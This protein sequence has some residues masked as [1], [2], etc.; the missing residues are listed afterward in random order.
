[1]TRVEKYALCNF[2]VFSIC[3][4]QVKTDAAFVVALIFAIVSGTVFVLAGKHD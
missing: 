1:M 3:A 4:T 2:I